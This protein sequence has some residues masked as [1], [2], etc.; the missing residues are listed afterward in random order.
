MSLFG[1]PNIEKMK[2]KRDICGLADVLLKYRKDDKVRTA[3]AAALGELREPQAIT[4]LA[5]ALADTDSR[6]RGSAASALAQIGD[7]TAIPPLVNALKERSEN[8]IADALV[9]FGER[10]LIM[11]FQGLKTAYQ[12]VGEAEQ[13]LE[14]LK[15]LKPFVVRLL[16]A[17]SDEQ[18]RI[19]A[20]VM[21]NMPS[22]VDFAELMK[23]VS[24]YQNSIKDLEKNMA[25]LRRGLTAIGRISGAQGGRILLLFAENKDIESLREAA[26]KEIHRCVDTLPTHFLIEMMQSTESPVRLEAIQALKSRPAEVPETVFLEALTDKDNAV[27][28]LAV[29]SVGAARE[30]FQPLLEVLGNDQVREIRLAA[31][32]A[33]QKI[34]EMQSQLVEPVI[35]CLTDPEESIRQEAAIWLGQ[36]MAT[37]A[38]IP[39]ITAWTKAP[40]QEIA[41]ALG[42]LKDERA[43]APL[44]SGYKNHDHVIRTAIVTALGS[45]GS[46]DSIDMLIGALDDRDG[47]VAG[48]AVEALV[49]IGH[50]AMQP[51]LETIDLKKPGVGKALDR[52][53]WQP[54]NGIKG[55]IFWIQKRQWSEC[56]RIGEPAVP[57]LIEHLQN[58]DDRIPVIDALQQIRDA[59]A[60][61]PLLVCLKDTQKPVRQAAASALVV[62]YKSSKIGAAE[63]QAIFAQQDRMLERH[64]D[65][66]GHADYAARYSDC[67]SDTHTDNATHEDHGI[68]INLQL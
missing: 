59:R 34:G 28:R 33:L 10:S 19:W 43:I 5:N 38:A 68:G 37:E 11:L 9:S 16:S 35:A 45:I 12:T 24:A 60:V 42:Q 54:D 55:T 13:L 66:K 57:I 40:T 47:K 49:K 52:L 21:K 20:A 1:P 23:A 61:E 67:P 22:E 58:V 39:L 51:L 3:A 48:A 41:G 27:R 65:S 64:V 29:E 50:P 30:A 53:G 4:D 6:V 15:E 62:L 2:A 63:K 56:V 32:R 14:Q 25:F 46:V 31:L 26:V 18:N 17:S 44:I 7:D 8:E 36:T